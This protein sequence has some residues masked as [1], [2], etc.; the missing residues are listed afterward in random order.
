MSTSVA[1][2]VLVVLLSICGAF[3]WLAA[4]AFLLTPIAN[5]QVRLVSLRA[6]LADVSQR[7]F[8]AQSELAALKSKRIDADDLFFV[9]PDGTGSASAVQERVR[10]A[11]AKAG[12][13]LISSQAVLDESAHGAVRIQV[14]VRARL[15]EA[16]LF[17]LLRRLQVGD[18]PTLL[19]G[20]EVGVSPG[21]GG[22]P[23][24]D[25]TAVLTA[26]HTDAR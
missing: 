9:S 4:D 19:N 3:T 20:F 23:P 13:V 21:V 18:P 5:E 16:G 25:F 12:G 26:F 11:I 24:L 17:D 10:E 15:D 22:Q 6:D 1:R 14:L 7:A 2:I 8:V